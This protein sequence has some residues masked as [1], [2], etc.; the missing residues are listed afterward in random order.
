MAKWLMDSPDSATRLRG[1]ERAA[2]VGSAESILQLTKRAEKASWK[3]DPRE[4]LVLVRALA[5]FADR[6][7]VRDALEAFVGATMG[8][9]RAAISPEDADPTGRFE[10]A[11]QT[12]A[13]A[14]VR[15]GDAK[16]IAKLVKMVVGGEVGADAARRALTSVHL[17]PS[18]TFE[19]NALTFAPGI[20]LAADIGDPGAAAGLRNA[21][22][23]TAS[24]VRAAAIV[25]LAELRDASTEAV[26]KEALADHSPHVRIAGARA[27]AMIGAADRFKAVL[28][29]IEDDATLDAGIE[30]AKTTA[31]QPI[32]KA[33][34]RRLATSSSLDER[35]AVAV[36]LGKIDAIDALRALAAFVK[37]PAVASDVAHAIATS[38]NSDAMRVI[39]KMIADAKTSTLGIRAF[40]ARNRATGD[41]SAAAE[42]AIESFRASRDGSRRALGV[43]ASLMTG[44]GDLRAALDDRDARV[45]RAAVLA[46]QDARFASDR[47]ILHDRVSKETDEPTRELSAILLLD[48][49]ARTHVPTLALV[50]RAKSGAADA[51]LSAYARATRKAEGVDDAVAQELAS[52]DAITRAHAARGLGESGAPDATG[53]LA[54]AYKEET[55][56]EV[57]R[58]IVLA[59]A[60][61]SPPGSISR[62]ATLQLASSLDPD[63]TTRLYAVRGLS[64]LSPVGAPEITEVGWL[65]V[66]TND[67]TKPPLGMMGSV[68]R[69]DGFALPVVFD[70]EGYALV[71]SMPPGRARLVL[72][73][74]FA[75]D[76]D[77]PQEKPPQ[78]K[79]KSSP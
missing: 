36:A 64:G 29:L 15:S 43:F 75:P 10:L 51:P 4:A 41:K 11:R 26:A 69:S 7:V 22:H 25:A 72:A 76:K 19:A 32:V 67:A 79:T 59:L 48:A 30:L 16:K 78:E 49:N 68:L 24:S 3:N 9:P 54:S 66:E 17:P 23:A 46:M 27:L 31:D 57:R 18:F 74:R 62:V 56:T 14:L 60:S 20:E 71:P 65:H 1:I 2:S 28:A 47:K 52:P 61:A 39:E 58:A 63:P 53:L 8:T 34:A 44:G 45:R 70:D 38:P 21:S 40:V 77:A 5:P 35:R 13:L 33:L 73:P 55:E 37:D 12:A 6:G 42:D 50:D